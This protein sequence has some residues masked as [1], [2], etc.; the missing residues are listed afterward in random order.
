M[1]GEYRDKAQTEFATRVEIEK[2]A[3]PFL[4]MLFCVYS[5]VM[6]SLCTICTA[7]CIRM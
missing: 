7:L 4:S 6:H 1:E 2:Q 5:T 3:R